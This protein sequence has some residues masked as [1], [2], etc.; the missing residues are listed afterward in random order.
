[1]TIEMCA[2]D[3]TLACRR[4]VSGGQP[5]FRDRAR[6]AFTLVEILVVIAIIA[7]LI[8]L[9]LPA[10]Q[11][12]REA[13][14]RTGCANNVLQVGLA[15]HQHEFHREKFPAGVTDAVGPIQNVP[16]GQHV[17]WI[18]RILPYLDENNLARHFKVD[19]GAYAEANAPVRAVVIS[20][21]ICPSSSGGSTVGVGEDSNTGEG[22]LAAVSSYAGCHHDAEAPIDAG[23]H[24]MLFLNSGVRFKDILDGSSRTLLVGELRPSWDSWDGITPNRDFGWVSGTR[25]TLRNTSAV[26]PRPPLFSEVEEANLANPLFVGSFGSEHQGGII[27]TA[28]ADGSI[29][30]ITCDID[31]DVLRQLGNRADEEIPINSE[32]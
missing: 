21:L 30:M 27:V 8:G 3:Q 29:H 32:W 26:M 11:S 7:T 2:R 12:A 6:D 19:E 1:M 17:S 5:W 23:N 20:T 15:L 25:S 18:V 4:D 9:L 16:E 14:R 24:G 31:P 28:C 13:A 10:V 22:R